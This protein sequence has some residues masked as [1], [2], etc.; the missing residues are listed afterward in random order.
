MPEALTRTLEQF[1]G[2]RRLM[3]GLVGAGT[4]GV[5][6]AVAQWAMAPAMVPL[7]QGLPMEEVG[8]I[9]QRLDEAAIEY[10]LERGGTALAVAEGDLARARVALAQEGY[11]SRGE[12]GWELFDQAAWGMTDFTQ[13]VNYRRALEGELERTIS[14]MRGVERAQVHLAIQKRSVLKPTGPAAQASVV[15]ALRSGARPDQSMV[16]GIASL[17]AGSVEGMEKEYVTILDD[18]GRLLSTKDSEFDPAGLTARQLA[19]QREVEKHL[20][21]KAYQLVEPVVGTGNI[22]VQVA[23]FLNFDQLGRTVE[24]FDVEQQATVSEDRSE[25]IPG[26]EEQGASSLTV[27]STYET[28]RSIE[29]FNRQGAQLE[30][31]TV[32]V[33]V[34]DRSLEDGGETAYQPRTQEELTRVESLVRNALG[35]TDERGDAITVLSLPFDDSPVLPETVEEGTDVMALVLAGLRPTIGLLGLVMAFV[36][37]LRLMSSIK[38]AAPAPARG[39]TLPPGEDSR[40]SRTALSDGRSREGEGPQRRMAPP[41]Q[42]NLELADPSITAKVVRAW[43]K[44]E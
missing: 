40:D 5:M 10:T 2:S 14:T 22:T 34:N 17:V 28:P 26:N 3:L 25:I 11:P 36:L 42:P 30:R 33:V 4:L 13:R 38:S 27:N 1:G 35:V 37:A 23:A 6:W 16:E 8:A 20:E 24:T 12:P 43:M 31:L 39:T 9:T 32:A 29:T 7:F 44:E 18:S 19:I 41:E 21:D 15:V